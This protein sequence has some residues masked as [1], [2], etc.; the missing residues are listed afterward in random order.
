MK[1]NETRKINSIQLTK[2]EENFL[3]ELWK[4][5]VNWTELGFNDFDGDDIKTVLT[6]IIEFTMDSDFNGIIKMDD[7]V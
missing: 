5:A 3:T 6:D 2:G 1:I 4:V 7:I